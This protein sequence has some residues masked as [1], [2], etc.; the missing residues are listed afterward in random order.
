MELLAAVFLGAFFF[1]LL[2]CLVTILLGAGH[3][4][5]GFHAEGLHGGHAGL[6]GGD[7]GSGLGPFNLTALTAFI[8][9]FGG[10]GY[11]ALTNWRLAVGASI[12]LAVVA[13]L[14]GWAVV[15][16]FLTR[17]LTRGEHPLREEDFR[18]EGTVARVTVPIRQGRI[19]EIQYSRAGTRRS[20]G[21]RS[22]DGS[23]IP[24]DTE[25]VIVRYEA[26]LAYVQPWEQFVAAEPV[27]ERR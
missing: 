7:H 2:T 22:L 24:R 17:V 5:F 26:G 25:V 13:G 11:L 18:A 8:A 1:G 19:G 12:G 9:W 6:D 27:T 20:D 4:D 23:E 15:Y 10:I 16:L 14:L 3:L 21:A